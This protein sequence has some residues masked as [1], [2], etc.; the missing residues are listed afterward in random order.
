MVMEVLLQW[1]QDPALFDEQW[2]HY[3][4]KRKQEEKI[5]QSEERY[6]PTQVYKI[7]KIPAEN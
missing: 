6:Y 3:T 4:P 5:S 7:Y 1:I 2:K